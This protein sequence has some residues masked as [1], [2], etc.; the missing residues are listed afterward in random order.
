MVKLTSQPLENFCGFFCFPYSSVAL[1][2]F[3]FEQIYLLTVPYLPNT[4]WIFLCHLQM[5][6]AK[7]LYDQWW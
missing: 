3:T 1:S 5:V 4:A 2:H 6:P 7:N